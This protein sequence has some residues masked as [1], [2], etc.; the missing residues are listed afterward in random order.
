MRVPG[1]RARDRALARAGGLW[2]HVDRLGLARRRLT[3]ALATK[4]DDV[5]HRR[6][7]LADAPQG[8]N[9]RFP[10]LDESC[11]GFTEPAPAPPRKDPGGGG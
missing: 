4:H 1:A 7:G 11:D 8:C 10:E 9:R 2:C 5:G 3:T 6:T